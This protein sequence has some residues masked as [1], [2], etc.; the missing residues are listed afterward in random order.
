MQGPADVTGRRPRTSETRVVGLAPKT[1]FDRLWDE[2]A[3]R[4]LGLRW[5]KP[6]PL[7]DA[8]PSW[9]RIAALLLEPGQSTF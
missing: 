6:L 5:D 2:L 9:G 1:G 3:V 4:S 8:Q 7:R